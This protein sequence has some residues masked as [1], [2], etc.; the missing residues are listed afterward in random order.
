MKPTVFANVTHAT[1]WIAKEEI[2]GQ[3]LSILTY[4][5]EAE[6]IEIANDARWGSPACVKLGRPGTR[7]PC[8]AQSRC[9]PNYIASIQ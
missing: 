5:T 6:A 1:C 2:F 4:K 9:R 3:V 8:G 7:E